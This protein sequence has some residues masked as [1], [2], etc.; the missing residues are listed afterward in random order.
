MEDEEFGLC[1]WISSF[2]GSNMSCTGYVSL[3]DGRI[4]TSILFQL[5]VFKS[6]A[7]T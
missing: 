7:I 3:T 4:L 1:D 2:P 6:K 5:F